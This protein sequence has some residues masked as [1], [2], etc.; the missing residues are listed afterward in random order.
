MDRE[1][2]RR[3]V[4]RE[5]GGGGWRGRQ[6]D[7]EEGGRGDGRTGRRGEEGGQVGGEEAGLCCHLAPARPRA[8][9]LVTSARGRLPL[10]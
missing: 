9:S 2:K 1:E 3:R 4:D 6:V 10:P 7:G 5:V 8:L